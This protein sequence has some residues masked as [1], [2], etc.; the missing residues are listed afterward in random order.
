MLIEI[1]LSEEKKRWKM[2]P[3]CYF[4]GDLLINV[5]TQGDH[6]REDFFLS[7]GWKC[8]L[9]GSNK[10]FGLQCVEISDMLY[11]TKVNFHGSG[12]RKKQ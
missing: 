1:D 3:S 2:F 9:S 4:S 6:E 11:A 10:P 5:S 12:L 7:H 8:F